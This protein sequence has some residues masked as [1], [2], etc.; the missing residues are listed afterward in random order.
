MVQLSTVH[1]I[2]TS[3]IQQPLVAVIAGGTSGIG[4]YILQALVRAHNSG[5]KGVRVYIVGRNAQKGEERIKECRQLCPDG[6][7]RFVK[8]DL[9]L[10][11]EVDVACSEILAQEAK[12]KNGRVDMLYMTQGEV[13]FG[14][15]CDT[16]ECLDLSMVLLY[17]SRMK[18][19]TQLLPLL[20]ASTLPAHVVSV[21]AA[22]MESYGS[23]FP[24]DLSLDKPSNFSFANARSHSVYMTTLFFE[25]LANQN[26]GKVA[27]VHAYPFI[28][29][30]PAYSSSTMPW[31]FRSLWWLLGGLVTRFIAL[32]AEESGDRHLSL[33]GP[34]Y[35]PRSS[36]GHDREDNVLS[37][38]GVRGGGAYAVDSTGESTPKQDRRAKDY[39]GLPKDM[40]DRVWE[41]TIG[42]FKMIE[43]RNRK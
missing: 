33:S 37:T 41:H 14:S 19:T 3:L 42:V 27:F 25:Q 20:R 36:A 2:N 28:V 39:S 11:R 18:L 30:T 38:D 40:A 29:V 15:R 7:F 34:R 24:Q 4:E 9:S 17:Y 6:D 13:K 35:P 8:A 31:W 22:G 1:A 23:F 43:D 10:L 16:D 12:E 21:Y 26:E 32:S 5:G